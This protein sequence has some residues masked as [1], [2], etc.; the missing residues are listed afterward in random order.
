MERRVVIT[1]LG[2]ICPIGNNVKESFKGIKEKRNGID[3]ITLFDTETY[4]ATLAGEVKNYNPTDYF[5]VKQ[6][7]RLDRSSQFALIAAREAINDSKIDKE[8]TD[9]ERMGV[10]VGSGIGG[11]ITI[12]NQC[13]TKVN[14]GHGKISP[15]FIPK[16]IA[17][18]PARKYCNRIRLQGRVNFYSYSMCIIYSFNR[19][20]I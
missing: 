16:S 7:K 12:Q 15:M 10:F 19:R 9:F 14:K 18:M 1:G 20:S 17:N 11:L 2:A 5:D 4:K 3:K 8:N 13:E 6:A